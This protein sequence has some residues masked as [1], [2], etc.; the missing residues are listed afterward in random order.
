M[1]D[2]VHDIEIFGKAIGNDARYRIIQVL[3]GG[4]HTV[5]DIVDATG[6]AQSLVSQHLRTLR[7]GRIVLSR[8]DKQSVY[9]R[10]NVEH[11]I[12]LLEQII[13]SMRKCPKYKDCSG[14]KSH[15]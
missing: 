6:M 5:S 15:G 1:S 3:L 12:G 4:E 8:R 2:V 13:K 7:E 9:Y 11:I 14:K 10:L